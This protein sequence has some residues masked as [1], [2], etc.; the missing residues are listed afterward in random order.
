MLSKEIEIKFR[1]DDEKEMSKKLESIGARKTEEGLEHNL[2]FDNGEIRDSGFLLRLRKFNNR[3]LLT[4][5]KAITKKEFKEA[6]EVQTDVKDFEGM[7]EILINLGYEIFWVYEKHKT[8]FSLGNTLICV[9]RLPF[10]TYM[11]IEGNENAIRNVIERLGLDPKK[12][13]TKTYLELYQDFC[14]EQGKEM[15]NLIFWRKAR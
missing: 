7:K 4:F 5:K 12:G 9:D 1:V 14:K 13:I 3:S 15:E 8:N 2:V 11:E 10:G 6:D